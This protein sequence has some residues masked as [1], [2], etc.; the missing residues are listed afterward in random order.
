[1]L[2]KLVHQIIDEKRAW[3]PIETAQK[4]K[5]ELSQKGYNVHTGQGRWTKAI[6]IEL[7]ID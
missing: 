4:V 5:E 6:E 3:V 7:Y 2:N 1:M